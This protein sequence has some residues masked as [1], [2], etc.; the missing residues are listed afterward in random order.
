MRTKKITP[1]SRFVKDPRGFHMAWRAVDVEIHHSPV[2]ESFSQPSTL[3][4]LGHDFHSA[5][6]IKDMPDEIPMRMDFFGHG[7]M[8]ESDENLKKMLARYKVS[9]EDYN[10]GLRNTYYHKGVGEEHRIV[11]PM[12]LDHYHMMDKIA[13]HSVPR[14][15]SVYRGFGREF[16][17]HHLKPGAYVHDHAYVSTSF[18]KHQ[19]RIFGAHNGYGMLSMARIEVPAGTRGFHVDHVT[20]PYDHENEFLLH[21]GT[22]FQVYGHSTHTNPHSG[23]NLHLVHMRVVNQHPAPLSET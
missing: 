20:N 5:P 10:H 17:I 18:S 8:I 14:T 15:Y 13:D 6:H 19:S 11:P 1:F 21:R 7:H 9:S 16:P 22:T 23:S 12:S 3:P 4:E 2:G